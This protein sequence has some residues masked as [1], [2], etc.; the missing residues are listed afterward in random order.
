VNERDQ[1]IQRR[2]VALAPGFEETR[3]VVGVVWN[4]T[5]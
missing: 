5:F 4:G 1:R 3:H 2:L